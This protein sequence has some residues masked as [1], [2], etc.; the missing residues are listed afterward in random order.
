MNNKILSFLGICKRAGR[1][2]IGN[3]AVIKCIETRQSKLIIVANDISQKTEKGIISVC[4]M[5][6][7]NILRLQSSK[8]DLSMALGKYSAVISV[9]DEGFAKKLSKMIAETNKEENSI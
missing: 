3:D 8:D 2:T 1:L 4:E 9:N 6:K 7:I 5:Y